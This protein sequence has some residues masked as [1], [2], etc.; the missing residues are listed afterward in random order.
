MYFIQK[1]Y[2]KSALRFLC[3]FIRVQPPHLH[4]ILQTSMFANLLTCLQ[5][6][7]STTVVSA[8][9]TT[10]IMLLPHMPSS[11]VPHLPTLFNIYARLLFWGQ[12]ISHAPA[13]ADDEDTTAPAAWETSS[14][15]PDVDDQAIPHLSNYYTILYGLYPLN[16]MDYIRKPQR[17]LRHANAPSTDDIDVQPTELRHRSETFRRNHLLHPNFYSLTVESEKTDFSRWIKSEAAEVVADC[18]GLCTETGLYNF[19]DLSVAV[20]GGVGSRADTDAGDMEANKAD[21]ALLSGSAG[22]TEGWRNSQQTDSASSNQTPAT[23]MR[24]S[25]QSSSAGL[26]RTAGTDSPTLTLSAS[27]TQL[28]D[29]IQS[30]K[31]IKSGLHQSL[32]NDS[33]PSLLSNQESGQGPAQAPAALSSAPPLIPGMAAS[34]LSLSNSANTQVAHLQK[35]ILLLQNDLSFER[36]LKQQHMAHIGDLRRRQMAEAASEAE[37]QNLILTN[38]NLRSRFEESKKAEMQ[39]KKESEKSRAMAKKWEADLANKLKNLREESKKTHSDLEAVQ[40]E[41]DESRQECHKLRQLVCAA[42]V[43]E[44]TWRQNAQSAEVASADADRLKNEI[45]RLTKAE[46]DYQSRDLQRQAAVDSASQAESEV[47]AFRMKISSLEHDT[48]RA[49]SMFQSQVAAL[50]AQL[51]DTQEERERAPSASANLAVGSAL[52]ASRAK[53]A[54]LQKQYGLLNRKYTALQSSLLDMQSEQEQSQQRAPP[55]VQPSLPQTDNL[56]MSTSPVLV[57]SRSHRAPSNTTTGSSPTG[58]RQVTSQEA[59]S[60]DQRPFGR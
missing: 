4:Q 28:Q 8:A 22:H 38:R 60:P 51:S 50:Q 18:M 17:Y 1:A 6:D 19:A 13:H 56:S 30:N 47:E 25:S 46:R 39:T 43:K 5:Q 31:A 58:L 55:I 2:R 49:Q 35:Q 11:L 3:D 36:Y 23:M 26:G 15:D 21:V 48:Q 20:P 59:S 16:F 14:F 29:L 40:R 41:L 44:L 33:V 34:P 12:E 10:I 53:Q 37:T 7:T 52:A 42:E 45:T 32:G 9:L 24:R 27:H 54:E 57:K